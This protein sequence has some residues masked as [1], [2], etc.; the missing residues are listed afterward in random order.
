[1]KHSIFLRKLSTVTVMGALLAACSANSGPVDNGGPPPPPPIDGLVCVEP[2]LE[3]NGATATFEASPN[4]VGC[5]VANPGLAIDGNLDTVATMTMPLSLLGGS[6][7][8]AVS[9]GPGAPQPTPA[10]PGF[11]VRDPGFSL[12]DL[13]L[14]GVVTISTLLDG[15]V[16]ESDVTFSL[17][18]LDLLGLIQG[19]GGSTTGLSAIIIEASLPFDAIALNLFSLVGI[20]LELDVA[21]ACRHFVPVENAS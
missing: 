11:I 14:L 15:E 20:G 3:Q 7:S 19:F 1:M 8:F 18:D 16:Q 10:L 2:F 4:C 13:N 17:L 21:G 5:E 9:S 6:L 12:L